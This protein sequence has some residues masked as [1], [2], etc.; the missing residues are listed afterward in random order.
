MSTR[1][2]SLSFLNK[3][4]RRGKIG[5][6]LT[7]FPGLSFLNK[8]KR[9][10]RSI[11]RY[12]RAIKTTV[13]THPIHANVTS[14]C[15]NCKTLVHS[16]FSKKNVNLTID[17]LYMPRDPTFGRTDPKFLRGVRICTPFRVPVPERRVIAFRSESTGTF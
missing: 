2:P 17:L 7:R 11:I 8:H 5:D 14:L 4:K 10:G 9:R 13:H 12:A 3:H 16:P 15:N 6:W 1:F